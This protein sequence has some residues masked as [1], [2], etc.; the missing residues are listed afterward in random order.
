MSKFNLPNPVVLS[1]TAAM[2]LMLCLAGRASAADVTGTWVWTS[3]HDN[4]TTTIAIRLRQ[5][6]EKLTGTW[7]QKTTDELDIEGTVKDDIVSFTFLRPSPKYKMKYSGT[8]TGDVIKG[9]TEIDIDG[10]TGFVP[11]QATR[12][13]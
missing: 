6:G 2:G 11:W 10:K 7:A 5:N 12:Q 4:T 1:L 9:R 13:K 3:T 8:I